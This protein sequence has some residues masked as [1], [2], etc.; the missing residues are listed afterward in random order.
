MNPETAACRSYECV[1]CDMSWLG[2]I[3]NSICHPESGQSCKQGALQRQ[4]LPHCGNSY[5]WTRNRGQ[6]HTWA[7]GSHWPPSALPFLH[8]S[9]CGGCLLSKTAAMINRLLV[10]KTS[11]NICIT[12]IL[13][14]PAACL[15]YLQIN[16]T[17]FVPNLQEADENLAVTPKDI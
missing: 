3:K 11:T 15:Q 4:S 14:I 17:V 1:L 16:S 5:R 8:R 12:L 6:G 13:N 10:Y 2:S 7:L 9:P